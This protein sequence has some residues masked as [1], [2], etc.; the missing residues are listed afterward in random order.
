MSHQ[1]QP[2]AKLAEYC[3]D[4]NPVIA[5]EFEP[6]RGW[7]RAGFR[8][9]ASVAWLRKRRRAGV[10]AVAVEFADGSRRADFRIEELV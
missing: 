9:R 6:G 5:Q 1:M 4:G 2:I 8:K 10:T 3:G 7:R